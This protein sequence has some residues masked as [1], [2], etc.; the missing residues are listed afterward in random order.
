MR[1]NFKPIKFPCVIVHDVE[2][3]NYAYIAYSVEDGRDSTDKA[4]I[5]ATLEAQE[6]CQMGMM[7]GEYRIK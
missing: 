4:L 6:V 2:D 1:K 3:D 7:T 5:G